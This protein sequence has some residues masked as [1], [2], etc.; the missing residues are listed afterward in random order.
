MATII[1]WVLRRAKWFLYI[2]PNS[3]NVDFMILT[4]DEETESGE[5]S[6]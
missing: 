6:K 4:V 3:H 2:D 1:S 5:A